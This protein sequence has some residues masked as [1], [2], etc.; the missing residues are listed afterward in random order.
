VPT[1]RENKTPVTTTVPPPERVAA[2]TPV[3]TTNSIISPGT[4]QTRND[5]NALAYGLAVANRNGQV[6]VGSRTW[7]KAQDAIRL[8]RRGQ[9]RESAIS[10]SGIP[11]EIFNQLIEWGQR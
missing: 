5:A 8:L 7:N 4:P 9:S 11:E 1:V 3:K 10:H 2:V 6:K